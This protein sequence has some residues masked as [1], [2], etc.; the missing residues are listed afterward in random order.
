[1]MISALAAEPIASTHADATAPS[2]NFIFYPIPKIGFCHRQMQ[3]PAFRGKKAIAVPFANPA[4]RLA[5]TFFG[6]MLL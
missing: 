3:N 2:K 6:R 1:M 5:F 4:D